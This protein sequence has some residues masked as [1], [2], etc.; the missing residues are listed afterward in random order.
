MIPE[1]HRPLAV[2]RIGAAGVE[3]VVE[4][5][6]AECA[7]LAQRIQLPS[8]L[9][10][11]CAFRLERDHADVDGKAEHHLRHG[12]AGL[13]GFEGRLRSLGVV[14]TDDLDT[15]AGEVQGSI[16]PQAVGWFVL[17]GLAALAA[18][19]VIGHAVARQA[20]TERLSFR[21]ALWRCWPP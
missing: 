10:L 2:D 8:V 7:A 20:V 3:V 17:A 12:A 18:L 14:G 6:A 19:A 13:T 11:R 5:T 21:W 4:A 1:L 15:L 9:D 16:R